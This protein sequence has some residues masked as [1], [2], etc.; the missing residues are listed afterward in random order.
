M[1]VN[2]M[3]AAM[4]AMV[5][6]AGV[7]PA[8]EAQV[9]AETVTVAP[10]V[11][12]VPVE[13]TMWHHALDAGLEGAIVRQ[14]VDDFNAA[15][16][17]WRVVLPERSDAPYAEAVAAAAEAGD[18]PD[19]LDVEAVRVAAW[20][21]YLA[22]LDLP[23]EALA[24]LRPTAI[25]RLDGTVVSAGA[26]ETALALIA[27]RSVLEDLG[28][29]VPTADAPWDRDAFRTALEKIAATGAFA[30]PLDVG[31]VWGEAWYAHAVRPFVASAGGS[32]DH[33]GMTAEPMRDV[34]AWWRDLFDAGFVEGAGQTPRQRL[35][36]FIEGRYAMTWNG[37]WAV[38]AAV[39]EFGDD[40]VVLPPPDFGEGAKTATSS[41]HFAVSATS[42]HPDGGAAFIA[43]VLQPNYQRLFADGIG[44]LPASRAAAEGSIYYDEES[45]MTPFLDIA[46]RFAVPVPEDPAHAP[47]MAAF[48]EALARIAAGADIDEALNDAATAIAPADA[49]VP[50]AKE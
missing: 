34:A 32:I 8:Q 45:A 35:G 27:R 21:G 40:V 33:E 17:A 2:R 25:G 43:H 12:R 15:Q 37:N 11:A 29:R 26:W 28:I 30:Y 14:I 4:V 50:P 5:A 23:A 1:A 3:L 19:I 47:A 36:G 16:E 22:P 44:V 46:E 20:S 6:W 9:P 39:E 10:E 13:L 18:L 41:W 42:E 48:G 38:V 31:A 24:D 49:E 7:A